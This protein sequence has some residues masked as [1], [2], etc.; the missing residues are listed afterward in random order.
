MSKKA[1]NQAKK[2]E[3]ISELADTRKKILNAAS[4]LPPGKHAQV[5]L[6]VWTIKDLLAHLAG[7][8]Y[9][10]A[11][12]IQAILAG[13]LPAFYEHYD[14]DWRT[15][16]AQLVSEHERHDFAE[17]LTSVEDSHR[18]L[19]ELV[20]TLPAEE[21]DKDTGVRFRGYKVT[22]SRTL[23]AE[24]KDEKVHHAQIEEFAQRND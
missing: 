20:R 4:S 1:N 14:R 8:D 19:V 6:G 5:F 13:R 17:L 9:A 22:I 12:A 24:V 18:E 16:N 11:E 2:K 21:L 7:W 10:N 23:E 3:I 15:F